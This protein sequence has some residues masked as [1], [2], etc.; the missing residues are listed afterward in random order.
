MSETDIE[1]IKERIEDGKERE[2][3]LRQKK[4]AAEAKLNELK[5]QLKELKETVDESGYELDNLD[6]VI[7]EKQSKLNG[8]VASYEQALD[9]AEKRFEQYDMED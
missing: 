7:N 1:E 5:R 8:L 4:A 2:E 9:E 3:E 6:E